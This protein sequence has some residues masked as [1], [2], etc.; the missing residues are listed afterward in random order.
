MRVW[1]DQDYCTGSGL[2]ELIEPR[3]F[4][5]GDNGLA[6][7]RAAEVPP[8]C[9]DEV[10]D[11]A[12]SCPGGCIRLE[13]RPLS[14]TYAS[15]LPAPRNPADR[16]NDDA[17]HTPLNSP[18]IRRHVRRGLRRIPVLHG[19]DTEVLRGSDNRRR[20]RGQLRSR[21]RGVADLVGAVHGHLCH[22]GD[23][24]QLDRGGP[25]TLAFIVLIVLAIANLG[26]TASWTADVAKVG[27]WFAL[28]D[29]FAAGL[30]RRRDRPQCQH[31]Q[32][33]PAALP[34]EARQGLTS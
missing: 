20:G 26:G 8:G 31:G 14:R 34:D 10:R 19:P 9:E 16:G 17:P 3:V 5:I 2:C 6:R 21:V 7:V 4:A 15:F 11:A 29:S 12:E 24:Y 13:P 32:G 30:P 25:F 28:L 23:L 33:T 1:I 22:R 27:G 18:G